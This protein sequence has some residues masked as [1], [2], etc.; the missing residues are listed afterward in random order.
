[1][2]RRPTV[3]D[4]FLKTPGGAGFWASF[5]AERAGLRPARERRNPAIGAVN[6]GRMPRPYG[7]Y[8]AGRTIVST[9]LEEA[10]RL[11][12]KGVEDETA[13]KDCTQAQSD[14]T[15]HPTFT[16]SHPL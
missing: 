12:C 8:G 6:I 10:M 13:G 2:K 3:Y 5:R 16:H 15:R 9:M 1:M 14:P 4:P 7:A 11:I